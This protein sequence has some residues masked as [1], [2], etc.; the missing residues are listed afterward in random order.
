MAPGF[1]FSGENEAQSEV[2]AFRSGPAKIRSS[3]RTMPEAEHIHR[4]RIVQQFVNDAIGAVNDLP[5]S[6]VAEFGNGS[7]HF[8]EFADG[9]RPIYEFVAEAAGVRRGIESNEADD[10]P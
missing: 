6:R 10:F 9:K 2:A 7:A 3:T 5:D 1:F 8:G 4:V